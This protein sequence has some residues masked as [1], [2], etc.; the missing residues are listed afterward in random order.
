MMTQSVQVIASVPGKVWLKA[1]RTENCRLCER[2]KGCAQRWFMGRQPETLSVE[3]QQSYAVGQ[4]LQ[5]VVADG[6]LIRSAFCLYGLPLLA[7]LSFAVLGLRVWGEHASIFCGMMGLLL[8]FWLA[9]IFINGWNM[10]HL[11][12][13]RV[14]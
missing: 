5:L 6:V 14:V 4:S 8:G 3:T 11:M 2:Q 1:T 7:L 10:T 13:L 12:Q 9:K